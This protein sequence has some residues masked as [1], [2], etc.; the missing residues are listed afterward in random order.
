MRDYSILRFRR[1][2]YVFILMCNSVLPVVVVLVIITRKYILIIAANT[3]RKISKVPAIINPIF[4]HRGLW[5][6]LLTLSFTLDCLLSKI[7]NMKILE[8][9]YSL[10]FGTKFWSGAQQRRRQFPFIFDCFII[11][12]ISMK[13]S[14]LIV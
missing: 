6:P 8:Y 2:F 14:R 11:L 7:I 13:I 5:V 12:M 1:K 4:K 9:L 10:Q 3:E